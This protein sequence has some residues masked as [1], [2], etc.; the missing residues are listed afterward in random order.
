M[1]IRALLATV[2]GAITVFVLGYLIFGLLTAPYVKEVAIQ[3]AGLRKEPPDF[4]LLILKNIV[5]AL[6]LVFIF[7]Y[8]AG[9][10]TFLGGLKNGAIVMLLVTLS[11]NLNLLSIMNLNTGVRAE[12][13]DVLGETV[14]FAIGGGVIGGVLGLMNGRAET[15]GE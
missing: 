9:I 13:L 12:I 8:L 3:Y 5:Q 14:R 10:R 7:E 6:L 15:A 1:N 4:T 2:A 11:G